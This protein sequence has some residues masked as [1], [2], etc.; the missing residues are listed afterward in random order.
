MA[1]AAATTVGEHGFTFG[2][3]YAREQQIARQCRNEA[4]HL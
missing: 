1:L 4:R 2:M 3:L